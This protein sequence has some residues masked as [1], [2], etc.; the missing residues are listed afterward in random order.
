MRVSEP[1]DRRPGH[2]ERRR[3]PRV[4]IPLEERKCLLGA[5]GRARDRGRDTARR[6]G[7]AVY[8]LRPP[9]GLSPKEA[10]RLGRYT[11]EA[12]SVL[13]ARA[14]AR[15]PRSAHS[16]ALFLRALMDQGHGLRAQPS[17][18]E[19]DELAGSIVVSKSN[20]HTIAPSSSP[21]HCSHGE[22]P[23]GR[24]SSRVTDKI[25]AHPS[26][27]RHD[28]LLLRNRGRDFRSSSVSPTP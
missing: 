24:R 28:N 11:V 23:S 3:S 13:G 21:P 7:S 1:K 8:S 25:T 20:F 17:R 18:F 16:R 12:R 2:G 10:R 14:R 15:A 27:S 6:R 19:R 22:F 9:F 5:P 4:P 26:Q